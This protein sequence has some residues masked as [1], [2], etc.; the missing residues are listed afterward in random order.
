[1]LKLGW[2]FDLPRSSSVLRTTVNN[3]GIISTS[4][5][6]ALSPTTKLSF[7]SDLDYSKHDYNF[8]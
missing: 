3:Q 8:G 5:Q 1:M 4:F 2:E 6:T 7:T